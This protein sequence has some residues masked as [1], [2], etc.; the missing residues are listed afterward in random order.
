MKCKKNN[1]RKCLIW[2]I[3][4]LCGVFCLKDDKYIISCSEERELKKNGKKDANKE[5]ERYQYNGQEYLCTGYISKLMGSFA[6]EVSLEYKEYSKKLTHLNKLIS[7]SVADGKNE[8]L[9]FKSKIIITDEEI[10]KAGKDTALIRTLEDH[11]NDIKISYTSKLNSCNTDG[12]NN[13]NEAKKL[14]ADYNSYFDTELKFC[15]QK[16]FVYWESLCTAYKKRNPNYK[17]LELKEDMLKTICKD[18]NPA[19]DFQIIQ[20]KDAFDQHREL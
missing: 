20:Y 12:N 19:K 14:L 6:T 3:N 17:D 15:L 7:D 4:W 2:P 1:G 11:K 16:I 5:L 13:M 18:G 9:N 10:T 8:T